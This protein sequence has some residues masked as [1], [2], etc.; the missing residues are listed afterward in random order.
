MAFGKSSKPKF[1]F[2]AE[3]WNKDK[4]LQTITQEFDAII[5]FDSAKNPAGK[6]YI[7]EDNRVV[8]A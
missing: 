1:E 8:K 6:L 3:V 2:Y 7:M 4:K 5:I